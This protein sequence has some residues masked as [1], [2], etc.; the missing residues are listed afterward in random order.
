VYKLCLSATLGYPNTV[1]LVLAF[2]IP[3]GA[4]DAVVSI[5]L[6][7]NT[8]TVMFNQYCGLVLP[9]DHLLAMIARFNLAMMIEF[10]LGKTYQ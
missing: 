10:D 1:A 8:K 7:N 6:G 4:K 2:L 9:S 5:F 3:V